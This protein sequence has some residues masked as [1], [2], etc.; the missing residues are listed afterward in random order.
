MS[1]TGHLLRKADCP[2]CQSTAPSFV[3]IQDKRYFRCLECDLVFLDP[4]NRLQREEEAAHYALHQND[5]DDAG[6]RTFL[7]RLAVPILARLA[8]AS[9]G[10]D[11]GCGPGPALAAMLGEAGHRVTLYDPMFQQ[12]ELALQRRYDFVVC[13]ETA[14]HFF[15]PLD[16]FKRLF[17]LLRP[18]G[19]LG[20]MT[21]FPPDTPA[22]FLRWHYPRD[23][24]HVMFLGPH[25]FA[26][27]AARLGM[28]FELAEA[29]IALLR[30]LPG[31]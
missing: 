6:Y 13:S 21:A 15:Q 4:R 24:T 3:V 18:G 25:C 30:R 20:V 2:L 23:P 17:A 7:S 10:L 12:D 11:Y 31:R 26:W 5:P 14:E 22:A 8:P 1:P 9:E 28:R 29:N 19:L 27:I 16:E